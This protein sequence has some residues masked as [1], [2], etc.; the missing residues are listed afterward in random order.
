MIN[1][2][3]GLAERRPD[4]SGSIKTFH[5]T[6]RTASF[7]RS[8][9]VASLMQRFYGKQINGTQEFYDLVAARLQPEDYLL[10]LGCG[11]GRKGIDFRAK[12]SYI[13][14]CDYTEDV[15]HNPYI[16]AGTR[17][18]AYSLP[19]LD[20]TF[21]VVIMDF[22]VEHLEFPEKCASEL[23]RILKPGG[24]VFFRTPNFYHYV[25]LI[26]YLTP[27]S[28]HETYLQW[29]NKSRE[30]DAFETFYRVNTRETVRR[31]FS[32]AGFTLEQVRMVEKEPTYLTFAAPA[33]LIGCG[34]ER[35]VN[36]YSS[37]ENFRANIFGFFSKPAGQTAEQANGQSS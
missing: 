23:F 28:F 35:L 10:D 26:A 30:T 13:V 36:N 5:T 9:R 12:C 27:H 31:I 32:Q 18:D 17:G 20:Q 37:L 1:R 6:N 25:A 33:F 7:M 34:Y 21:N 19:F 8:K 29:L 3:E 24:A 16:C 15:R 4:H 2:S 14:G 11:P 22:V